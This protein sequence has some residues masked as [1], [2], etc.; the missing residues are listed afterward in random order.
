MGEGMGPCF[1]K[2]GRKK[3]DERAGE[4]PLPRRIGRGVLAWVA[5]LERLDGGGDRQDDR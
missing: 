1:A 4:W 3:G 5:R 2:E